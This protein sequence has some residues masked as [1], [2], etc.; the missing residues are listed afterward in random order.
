MANTHCTDTEYSSSQYWSI[1]NASIT[2]LNLTTDFTLAA[3]IKPESIGVADGR[4]GLISK[5][6][7]SANNTFRYD[8]SYDATNLILLVGN[9][10]SIVNLS[11]AW[12]YSAGVW[13]HIAVQY[14]LASG[15]AT[16]YQ[17]GSSLGTT[18]GGVTSLNNAETEPFFI[19]ATNSG[20][21]AAFNDG[22]IDDVQ[23]YSNDTVSVS[24]LYNN[25]CAVSDSASGLQGRWKFDNNGNDSTANANNLTNNNGA[26]FSTDVAYSC[27]VGPV[28]MKTWD[29]LAT[30]SIKTMDGLAIG[31]VKTWNGLA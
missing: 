21:A 1:A 17:N 14:D 2:G 8:F 26:T 31:S 13:T 28:N 3:W 23:V 12:T 24:D 20:G 19:G 16:F 4:N 29:G 11:K 9:G 6:S 10:S 15:V 25:P 22:L 27:A 7:R 30:A 18:G 5:G